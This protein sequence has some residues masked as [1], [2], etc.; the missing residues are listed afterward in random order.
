MGFDWPLSERLSLRTHLDA[1]VD[2]LRAHMQIGGAAPGR[3][4]LFA[5]A[6]AAGLAA[7]FE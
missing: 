6:A 1:T 2:L 7:H 3:L 5:G 4:P